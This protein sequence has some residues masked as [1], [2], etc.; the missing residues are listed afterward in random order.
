MSRIQNV[1]KTLLLAFLALSLVDCGR[2]MIQGAFCNKNV[3]NQTIV[4]MDINDSSAYLTSYQRQSACLSL[5]SNLLPDTILIIATNQFYY[6]V[7][8]VT[9]FSNIVVTNLWTNGLAL[10][11]DRNG[12]INGWPLR[13]NSLNTK[14]YGQDCTVSWQ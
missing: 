1:F 11:I 13:E 7:N 14:F 8:G 6:T 3:M 4:D 10:P 12:S 2:C 5:A 9:S